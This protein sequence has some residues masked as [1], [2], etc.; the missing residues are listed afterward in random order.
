MT[1]LLGVI[2][3][4]GFYAMEGFRVLEKREAETPLGSPSAPLT[5]AESDGGA[6]AVFLPR[7]GERHQL[8]PSEVNYRANIWAL[9]AAGARQV[10]AVS[11]TGSLRE[12]FEPGHFAVPSQYFDNTRGTRARTFFGD[13]LV[14]H[15]STARPACPDLS[16]AL[17]RAA[18]KLGLP[19]HSGMTYACVEGPRLG[20]RAESFF[21]RDAAGADMVGM[22]NIP[23]VFLARE[24]QLCYATLAV[25]TDYD[26]WLD[27]PSRHA[28][29]EE[30]IK[31]FGDSV[32]KAKKI[33]AQLL[34][35]GLP[36]V[37][38]SYRRALDMAVLTPESAFSDSHRELLEVLRK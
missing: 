2:G 10:V 29:V 36:E 20:T 16:S 13:G 14:A 17:V 11:A 4:S 32:G 30:V 7:H 31:R 34:S 38:E 21:L 6:R 35:D 19:I 3:G 27:D 28:T 37:D 9:K 8:L 5:F 25:A 12:K 24:A 15:V 26:C 1:A 18:E 33:V 22:T 23:E